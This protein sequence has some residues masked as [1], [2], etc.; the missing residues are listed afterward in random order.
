M[1]SRVNMENIMANAPKG[2]G[3]QGILKTINELKAQCNRYGIKPTH[4]WIG[5]DII[6][7]LKA[8]KEPEPMSICGMT[9]IVQAENGVKVG[10]P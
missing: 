8:A 9:V 6:K 2:E 3:L 10:Q 5:P 7:A 4:I 1:S